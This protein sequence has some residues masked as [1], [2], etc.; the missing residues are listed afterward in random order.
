MTEPYVHVVFSGPD[1]LV[2]GFVLGVAAAQDSR[3]VVFAH[4]AGLREAGFARRFAELL[5]L[6]TEQ[7]EVLIPEVLLDKLRQAIEQQGRSIGVDLVKMQRIDS[8]RF[9]FKCEVFNRDE[10]DQIRQILN[11]DHPGVELRDLEQ[12]ESE[13]PEAKGSELYAP[14]HEYVFN[15]SGKVVG[16]VGAVCFVHEAL[17]SHPQAQV[18]PIDLKL[19]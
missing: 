11:S 9:K 13:H 2:R 3:P 8:A 17:A 5:H 12:H 6:T 18:E 4:E 10:A 14:A 1:E 7:T 19:E 16:T 15:G